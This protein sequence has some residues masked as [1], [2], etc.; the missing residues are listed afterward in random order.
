MPSR[1]SSVTVF[2][3]SV[4][5]SLQKPTAPDRPA[6]NVGVADSETDNRDLRDGDVEDYGM[7]SRCELIAKERP[8]LFDIAL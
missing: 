1:P 2:S 6:S 3:P 5:V 4:S 7:S 8:G